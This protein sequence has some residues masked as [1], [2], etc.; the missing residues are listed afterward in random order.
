[1]STRSRMAAVLARWRGRFRR[2]L[3]WL[4][5]PVDE[6]YDWDTDPDGRAW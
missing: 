4:G 6:H 2:F 1:M 5:E 3:R